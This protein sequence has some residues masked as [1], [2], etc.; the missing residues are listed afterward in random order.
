MKDYLVYASWT[1]LEFDNLLALQICI[2]NISMD[3]WK[4]SY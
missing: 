4:L 3:N 2:Q 1:Y